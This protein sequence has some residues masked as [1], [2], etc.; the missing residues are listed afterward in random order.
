MEKQTTTQQQTSLLAAPHRFFCTFIDYTIYNRNVC[1]IIYIMY[2]V[3]DIFLGWNKY[4]LNIV[5]LFRHGFVPMLYIVPNNGS[6]ERP[7][8]INKYFM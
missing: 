8:K 7:G 5:F 1:I 3:G 2:I 6:A 4:Y